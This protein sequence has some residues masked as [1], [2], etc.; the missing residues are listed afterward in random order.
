M[1]VVLRGLPEVLHA[2]VSV[3]FG[4]TSVSLPQDSMVYC[5]VSRR[6]ATRSLKNEWVVGGLNSTAGCHKMY[7]FGWVDFLINTTLDGY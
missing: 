2:R 3:S 4:G 7:L 1:V 5:A 6:L